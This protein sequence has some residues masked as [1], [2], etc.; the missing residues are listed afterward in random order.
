MSYILRFFFFFYRKG[1]ICFSFFSLQFGFWFFASAGVVFLRE[2]ESCLL[3]F[4]YQ[5][6]G[7]QFWIFRFASAFHQ[8][9]ISPSVHPFKGATYVKAQ[10]KRYQNEWAY[11]QTYMK[12]T[13][14]LIGLG[15]ILSPTVI[16]SLGCVFNLFQ[17]PQLMTRRS[18]TSTS[19]HRYKRSGEVIAR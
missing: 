6:D 10:K 5:P 19:A 12:L 18:F 2:G 11:T 15:H 7:F 9:P 13:N 17:E 16:L 4:T 14:N 8:G 3:V 1:F